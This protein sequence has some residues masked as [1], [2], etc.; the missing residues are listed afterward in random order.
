MR[1]EKIWK[2]Q[3]QITSSSKIKL[4]KKKNALTKL[5]SWKK[6]IISVSI[7]STHSYE[8]Q[9]FFSNFSKF[10]IKKYKEFLDHKL[11]KINFT[12]V[13][14]WAKSKNPNQDFY[15]DD[16]FTS[17]S[18][19]IS[20]LFSHIKFSDV[21][22]FTKI[23]FTS[24]KSQNHFVS[25][26]FV[27]INFIVSDFISDDKS[28][29]QKFKHKRFSKWKLR[30]KSKIEFFVRKKQLEQ[31]IQFLKNFIKKFFT[32]L[33]KLNIL[34]QKKISK[35]LQTVWLFMTERINEILNRTES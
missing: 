34:I 32:A 27:F 19:F 14:E 28:F 10:S 24:N 2:N 23:V 16:F 29:K 13:D 9:F 4:K 35:T 7:F 25:D 1:I 3:I 5:I 12:N 31:K 30:V 22:E 15:N 33:L 6:I 8:N 18:E 21:N 11:I 26:I 17:K 20:E